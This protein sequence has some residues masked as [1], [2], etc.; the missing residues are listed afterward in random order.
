M[1]EYLVKV[2]PGAAGNEQYS[3]HF[4][5]RKHYLLVFM[6]G[7]TGYVMD[8]SNIIRSVPLQN[9]EILSI[10]G[11][12]TVSL[13]EFNKKNPNI[14]RIPSR[15][16][17]FPEIQKKHEPVADQRANIDKIKPIKTQEPVKLSEEERIERG[18]KNVKKPSEDQIDKKIKTVGVGDGKPD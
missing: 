18:D 11:K 8:D 7:N 4:I 9:I 1:K 15:T 12:D 14:E 16:K 10:D 6:N 13:Q 17:D 3:Q 5:V 2:I